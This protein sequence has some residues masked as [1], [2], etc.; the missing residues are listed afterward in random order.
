MTEAIDILTAGSDT[1]AFSLSVG[2]WHI[3]QNP[4]IKTRLVEAL[5]EAV[6]DPTNIPSLL[7]LEKIPFLVRAP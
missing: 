6:P 4:A 1:T 3:L 5:K 2:T 7:E